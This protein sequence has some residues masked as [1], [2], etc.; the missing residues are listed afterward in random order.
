MIFSY[1]RD[2]CLRITTVFK[3]GNRIG[4]VKSYDDTYGFFQYRGVKDKKYFS[5][6]TLKEVKR[7]LE[8]YYREESNAQTM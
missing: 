6:N 8:N 5:A 2:N 3:D 7:Q 4:E 1:K